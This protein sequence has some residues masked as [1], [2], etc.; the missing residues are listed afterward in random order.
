MTK[1]K[2]SC[3]NKRMLYLLLG[4]KELLR[5]LFLLLNKFNGIESL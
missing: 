4:K 1:G 2:H 3:A 5:F